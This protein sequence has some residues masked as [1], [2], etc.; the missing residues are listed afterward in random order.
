MRLKPSV[1]FLAGLAVSACGDRQESGPA[2]GGASSVWPAVREF[3]SSGCVSLPDYE[4][5]AP[6]SR[7]VTR[8]SLPDGT[9]AERHITVVSADGDRTG[10]T[11]AYK[12]G[13][14]SQA[15]SGN[16]TTYVIGGLL[17]GGAS[18]QTA[19]TLTYDGDP[20][21]LIRALTKNET[22]HLTVQEITISNDGGESAARRTFAVRLLD[23]GRLQ[24]A[25]G[26]DSVRVYEMTTFSPGA[27]VEAPLRTVTR[28]Y[29]SD[30]RGW[31]LRRDDISGGTEKALSFTE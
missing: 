24:W 17:P 27:S 9:S 30:T 6:G 2:E 12:L 8:T 1:A 19:R 13:G 14:S 10:I 4:G 15:V 16:S 20:T 29:V 3:A 22:A 23:C 26:A 31:Y 21:T 11:S 18:G 7:I 5:P 25:G 28:N